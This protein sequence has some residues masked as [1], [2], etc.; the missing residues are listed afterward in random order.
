[1]LRA[2][3][4]VIRGCV[5]CY[6]GLESVRDTITL[7]VLGKL[8]QNEKSKPCALTGSLKYFKHLRVEFV[9]F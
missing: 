9:P 7:Y 4:A 8:Q 1:M 5:N 2:V 6:T 3:Y